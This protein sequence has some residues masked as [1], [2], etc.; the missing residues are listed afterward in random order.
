MPLLECLAEDS[1]E[2]FI[3]VSDNKEFLIV[4]VIIFKSCL[5]LFHQRHN[6][7]HTLKTLLAGVAVALMA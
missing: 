1:Q 5:H 7:F 6:P 4:D 2:I 3:R